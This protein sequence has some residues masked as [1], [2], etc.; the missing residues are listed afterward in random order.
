MPFLSWPIGSFEMSALEIPVARQ[1]RGGDQTVVVDGFRDAVRQRARVADTGGAAVTDQVEAH[2]V[3]VGLQAGGG[4]IVGD[5]LRTGRQRGLDPGLDRQ[6]QLLRLAR[7]QTGGDQDRRVGGVGAGGDGGDDDI[8]VAEIECLT[9]DLDAR[10][11]GG[12]AEDLAQGGFERRGGHGQ[13]DLVLRAFR[14][15][16]RGHNR[17]HVQF[18]HVREHGVFG[19]LVD[20]QPLSLGI[21]FHEGDARLVAAGSGQIA[22]GRR[23]DGEEAAGGAVFRGHVGDGGLVLDGQADDAGAEELDEFPDH[24]LLAQHLGD[25]QHQIGG[26]RAFRQGTG[27]AEADDFRD[28][29]GNGLAQHGG[30]GLDA[31]DAPAQHGQ[32]VDHGGVAVGA[33]HGVGIGDGRLALGHGPDGLGQVLEVHLMADARPGGHDAEIVEGRRTPAQEFVALDVALILALD[34]LVEGTRRAEMV[35]HDRVV[36]DQIDR[37]QRVDFCRIGAEGRHGVAHGGQV[38]NG[39][40]AGEV[41]HQDASRAE[42]DL[43]LDRALVLDP[44]SDRLEVGFAD[45]NPVLVAQQV[46]QQ[47]LHRARQAGN[48]GQAGFLSGRKAVIGVFLAPDGDVP[49]GLEAVD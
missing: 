15:G 7:H 44:G 25:R 42:G 5:H 46:L 38:D 33:D 12:A 43:V 48:P 3:E 11:V 6:A 18:Q 27:Q 20:P 26:G 39:G 14:T 22:D 29:H 16:D 30:L 36:D 45:G 40:H 2:G 1:H 32:A 13:F 8:A 41:L 19:G 49:A 31:A 35:D 37:I 4:Q 9:L 21:G 17:G 23:R 24:A 10:S 28:Q 34:V 47:H